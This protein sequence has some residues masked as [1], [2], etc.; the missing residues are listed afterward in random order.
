MKHLNM[1]YG[2]AENYASILRPDLLLK[3]NCKNIMEV[4]RINKVL[5]VSQVQTGGRRSEAT[6]ALEML[7]AQKFKY[8]GGLKMGG[9]NTPYGRALSASGSK[10]G[11]VRNS[12]ANAATYR[13]GRRSKMA[14][15]GGNSRSKSGKSTVTHRKP[16]A[17]ERAIGTTDR[18]W[19]AEWGGS[20]VIQS[21]LRNTIMYN[22]IDKMM[23]V[24]SFYDYTTKIQRNTIQITLHP[25]LLRLFP[26]VQNQMTSL[27]SLPED[28]QVIIF[29]S[30]QTEAQTTLVWN[31]LLQKE[32]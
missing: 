12:Q 20:G 29:T 3:L 9:N 13:P 17:G 4:P 15:P 10:S 24:L 18:L 6:L 19:A 16:K 14:P 31:A 5:V 8:T 21:C 22:W 27:W 26:E 25:N 28:V 11:R 1:T 32:I 30:A 2:Q 23:T 7:C